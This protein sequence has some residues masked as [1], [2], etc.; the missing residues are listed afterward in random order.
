ME[1]DAEGE[2]ADRACGYGAGIDNTFRDG[3][4]T[5]VGLFV[6]A[7]DVLAKATEE[8]ITVLSSELTAFDISGRLYAAGIGAC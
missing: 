2:L 6:I 3:V 1:T 8:G 5:V 7:N 4:K